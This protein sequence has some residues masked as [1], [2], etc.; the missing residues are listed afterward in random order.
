MTI[1]EADIA[2]AAQQLQSGNLVGLP[3]E[4][5]YGLAADARLD[6][7]VAKIY[8][9]K[10]R[11]QF[12]PLIVHVSSVKQAQEYVNFNPLAKQ[13]ADA[14]WPGPL[15]MVLPR[16]EGC[17]ISHL[18]SAGLNTL[19]VRVPNHPIALQL[20]RESGCPI[21]APSAN[22]SNQISPTTAQH[23]RDGFRGLDQPTTIIDGGPCQV[24][25]ESTVIAVAEDHVILLRPGGLSVE[26][27]QNICSLKLADKNS[28]IQS[29][30][31]LAKHYAPRHPLRLNV[32]HVEPNEVLLAFGEPLQ[33]KYTL[34][35]SVTGDII[36][37]AANLFAMLHQL[38][39]YPC[40]S[41]A[42]MPIPSTGLGLAIQDRLN[43]AAVR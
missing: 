41:I 22:P 19:A 17:G 7:A 2:F 4:T 25:L 18:V 14:F 1:L 13:L 21:A 23:V 40:T 43:R 28:S 26:S 34:N 10:G 33:A 42:V 6:L 11:P 9:T 15:T 35:L 36:E 8:A 20:I 16:K 30:G 37:A 27:I 24:G 3:T 39:E 29:P 12:N 5:V 31:M 32:S 38:D